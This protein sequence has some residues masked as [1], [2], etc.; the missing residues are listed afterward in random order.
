MRICLLICL[1][2]RKQ[3]LRAISNKSSVNGRPKWNELPTTTNLL[4][5]QVIEKVMSTIN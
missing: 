2:F 1:F 4:S 5:Y 3:K